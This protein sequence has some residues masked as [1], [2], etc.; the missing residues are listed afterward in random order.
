LKRF[1]YILKRIGGYFLKFLA[2]FIT[3]A[4]LY[5]LITGNFYIYRA[6]WYTFLHGQTGPDIFDG[7]YFYSR[8]VNP[9]KNQPWPISKKYN[10]NVLT[11]AQRT[12]L[13]DLST[14]SF[15]V[16]KNDSLLYEE[17]FDGFG[18][19][20][21][22]NSFSVAKSVVGLLI[23]VAHAEGK[24]K[25][26]DDPVGNYLI[27]YNE[28]NKK[29][30]T[31]RHLLTMSADMKW[32]ESAWNPLSDNAEAYYCTDLPG[33]MKSVD[34]GKNPGKVF[35]YKSGS[36]QVLSMIL[37]KVTGKTLSEYASEKIWKKVGAEDT[38]YWSLDT[39]NGT[40]K[41]YCCLYA[42][43]RDF[44]RLGK[45]MLHHGMWNGEQVIDSAYVAQSVVPA[46]L[47][48]TEGDKNDRYGYCW[49]ITNHK[50]K[51][52]F[53]AR[54]I[55]GQYV[56]CIPSENMVVVR[57]GHKRGAKRADDQPMDLFTMIDIALSFK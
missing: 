5:I 17:Y 53:Y 56:I 41:A 55:K 35:D 9:A 36:Q 44:G 14:T 48:T 20:E 31:I 38:A 7:N 45:L 51:K 22:S 28:G 50:G 24:I 46:N 32:N 19:R 10:K 11:T 34:Y 1:L 27:G 43:S 21:R 30:I 23:G 3:I 25:S 40:E 33:K 49:W 57:T 47:K 37:K 12:S 13:T 29:K 42:T 54:G 18:E 16:F 8:Q 4:N 15:L 6:V 39:K 2:A 26:L 52:V